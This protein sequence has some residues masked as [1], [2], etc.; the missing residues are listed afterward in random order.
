M[1]E[2]HRLSSFIELADTLG[3]K[4]SLVEQPTFDIFVAIVVPWGIKLQPSVIMA[5]SHH[6]GDKEKTTRYTFVE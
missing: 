5:L 1:R 3:C 6:R 4:G 2:A